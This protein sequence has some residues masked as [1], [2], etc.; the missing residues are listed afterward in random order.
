MY[1]INLD[2]DFIEFSSSIMRAVDAIRSIGKEASKTPIECRINAFYRALGLPAIVTETS[3]EK[4]PDPR[5]NGNVYKVEPQAVS[6]I[7]KE[8]K[9]RNEK[10]L[11][12]S[13]L[14]KQMSTAEQGVLDFNARSVLD[15]ISKKD[16]AR[17]QLFPMY[18][19]GD[20]PIFPVQ[21]R[22]TGAFVRSEESKKQDRVEYGTPLLEFIIT[23][24]FKGEGLYNQDTQKKATPPTSAAT[25]LY[26][27]FGKI[28]IE[29]IE[30]IGASLGNISDTMSDLKTRIDQAR[31]MTSTGVEQDSSGHP[32]QNTPINED[33]NSKA[34][35]DAQANEQKKY[36]ELKQARL[37][38]FEY[39]DTTITGPKKPG[40][41]NTKS[42]QEVLITRNLKKAMF[43]SQ[44]LNM[45]VNDGGNLE[46][47]V[48][49]TE[50]KKQKAQAELKKANSELEYVLG[51][52]SGLSG[53]DV[54]SIIYA[55]FS[56]EQNVLLSLLNDDA[57]KRAGEYFG[58]TIKRPM[59]IKE[60]VSKLEKE[61][62]VVMNKVAKN[63]AQDGH[64][65]KNPKKA[66]T[67]K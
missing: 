18:V 7:K 60:A 38:I 40:E 62:S 25:A 29:L 3:E 34:Q 10:S 33:P 39:D 4:K 65:E 67:K 51:T 11:N 1:N 27:E 55:L 22:I 59:G 8:L 63:I 36:T 48:N 13:T 19:D 61:V 24:R 53:T 45:V 20:I 31:T 12:L 35:L 37:L 30:Q 46:K 28:S 52:F 66:A 43:A 57:L 26:T 49:E 5:N 42:S 64:L 21:R 56:V 17:P 50:K 16:P 23:L 41:K 15:S 2:F 9:L 47:A 6:T 14:A 58:Q 54:M 32:E 44:F